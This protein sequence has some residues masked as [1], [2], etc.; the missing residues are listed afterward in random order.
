MCRLELYVDEL[1]WRQCDSE[2]KVLLNSIVNVCEDNMHRF[3]L[4]WNSIRTNIINTKKE[5]QG[6]NKV[7]SLIKREK[8]VDRDLH[9]L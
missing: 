3:L 9:K 7:F 6:S 5:Y 4:E 8:G 1:R 2:T